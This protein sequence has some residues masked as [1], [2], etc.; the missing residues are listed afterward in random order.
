VLNLDDTIAITQ[1]YCSSA[2]F[3]AVWKKTRSGRKKMA[4]KWLKLLDENYPQ[5]ADAARKLNEEDD[6][7]MYVSKKHKQEM[8]KSKSEKNKDERS[9]DCDTT[10]EC[11][12]RDSDSSNKR[13]G[14]DNSSTFKSSKFQRR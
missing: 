8:K 6:F 13:S 3:E 2:N 12:Y 4:V 5:L 9:D 11:D 10:L 14:S 7:V 1:N